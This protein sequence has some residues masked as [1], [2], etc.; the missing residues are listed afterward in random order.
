M[1]KIFSLLFFI[2]TLSIFASEPA[3]DETETLYRESERLTR[4]YIASCKILKNAAAGEITIIQKNDIENIIRV[5]EDNL[6]TF[7][8][9]ME[10]LK[11]LKKDYEDFSDSKKS[12]T[13]D[14][15]YLQQERLKDLNRNLENAIQLNKNAVETVSYTHLT[16]PTTS[17]V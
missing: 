1:K 3:I 6:E 12:S 4:E 9:S 14:A 2:C 8:K 11:K 7:K 15:L 13:L 17:R 10:V 16:L 5:Q